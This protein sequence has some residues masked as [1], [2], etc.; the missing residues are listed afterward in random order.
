MSPPYIL[1]K[2]IQ[3][4]YFFLFFFYFTSG[5][6]NHFGI[7]KA[8]NLKSK[9][10]SLNMSTGPDT[11]SLEPTPHECRMQS[12]ASS[13]NAMCVYKD[14]GHNKPWIMDDF[15]TDSNP[16]K[17]CYWTFSAME[18]CDH[19]TINWLM[20]EQMILTPQNIMDNMIIHV[21]NLRK[22]FEHR[23]DER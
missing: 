11:V 7:K 8:R 17:Y 1:K 15:K 14:S 23:L 21:E 20:F 13:F 10:E 5:T 22:V 3:Y 6:E 12:Y 4:F 18:I 2:E 9:P 16:K 19:C